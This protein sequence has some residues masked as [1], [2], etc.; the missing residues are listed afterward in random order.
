[1]D[2][3]SQEHRNRNMSRIRSK[4]TAPERIV[5]SFL[6]RNGFRFRLHVRN[7][8]GIPDIVLEKY[9]TVVE[10]YGCYWHRHKGC[11]HAY[12]PKTRKEF[13]QK[14]FDKNI[15]RDITTNQLLSDAGYK[16][17]V[18]WECEVTETKLKNICSQIRE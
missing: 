2:R 6:H 3:I 7:L 10:V 1:M 4:D 17:I 9:K 15:C 8:L 5:R 14:K 11:K 13:W 16:V 18:I 12:M